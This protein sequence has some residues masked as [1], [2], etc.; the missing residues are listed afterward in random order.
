MNEALE[1][2]NL[3]PGQLPKGTTRKGVERVELGP[4]KERKNAKPKRKDQGRIGPGG[5]GRAGSN[6]FDRAVALD[7]AD[8]KALGAAKRKKN[9]ALAK[10]REQ[11]A[12][13]KRKN[14]V[15][16]G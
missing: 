7:T 2:R 4:A 3:L 12:E 1:S 6:A 14:A 13:R 16:I 8:R 10:R 5:L 9:A 15:S 11:A